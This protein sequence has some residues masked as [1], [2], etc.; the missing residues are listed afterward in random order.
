MTAPTVSVVI[1]TLGRWSRLANA[2]HAARLQEGV[3]VQVVV[4]LDGAT[5]DEPLGEDVTV[6]RLPE[7]RGQAAARNAGL[8]AAEGEWVALL[9]D[10]DLW[11][12]QKLVRQLAEAE[13]ASADFAYASAL[14]VDG[15]HRPLRLTTAPPPARL[16][17]E[18]L[19]HNRFRP[20]T[21]TCSSVAA[22]PRS[23]ASTRS[24]RTSQTG[25]S[26]RG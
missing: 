2:V 10:D 6:C 3:Q 14:V 13:A 8:E 26:P 25:I 24:C 15:T 20:A 9:D 7:R 18:M 19:E 16:A 23:C 11:A 21:P 1:P 17:D 12:P 4:A 22:S 5:E